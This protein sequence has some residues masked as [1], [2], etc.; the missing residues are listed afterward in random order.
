MLTIVH[1]VT[2]KIPRWIIGLTVFS[3]LFLTGL[4]I[5]Y[6]N[7]IIIESPGSNSSPVFYVGPEFS[8]PI[9]F[10]RYLALILAGFGAAITFYYYRLF[11]M[12][13][14]REDAEYKH[15]S[16][17]IISMVLPFFLLVIFGILGT[18]DVL[19]KSLSPYLFSIFSCIIIFSIL[20]RPKFLNTSTIFKVQHQI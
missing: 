10:A 15:L 11:F 19:Q 12:K 13:M 18:L 3:A 1:L 8:L 9:P 16:R 7:E 20:F 4:R 17:W 6:F 2:P 5:L 14:N